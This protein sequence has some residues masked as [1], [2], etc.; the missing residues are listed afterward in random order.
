[1]RGSRSVVSS[2]VLLL[3]AVALSGLLAWL[4]DVAVSHYRGR[5]LRRVRAGADPATRDLADGKFRAGDSMTALLARHPPDQFIRHDEYTTA[6]YLNGN[7]ETYVAA[8]DGQLIYAKACGYR[9]PNYLFFDSGGSRSWYA[10][11]QQAILQRLQLMA[12][13]G[14]AAIGRLPSE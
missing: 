8:E 6:V 11:Y 13:A 7:R 3:L 1:M 5:Y 14:P 10:S 2:V 4:A 9:S 12:V